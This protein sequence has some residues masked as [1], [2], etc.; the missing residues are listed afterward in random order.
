M[1]LVLRTIHSLFELNGDLTSKLDF[2]KIDNP[3]VA[4][5]LRLAVLLL[6]EVSMIDTKTW[7]V[8]AEILAIIDHTRRPDARDA[9]AFGNIHLVLFGD[10]KRLAQ[11]IAHNLQQ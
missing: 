3:S 1:T 2:G 6:D 10:F 11:Q 4:V 8:I 9:D 7:Q 5:L